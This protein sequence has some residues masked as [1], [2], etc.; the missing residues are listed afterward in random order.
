MSPRNGSS[1]AASWRSQSQICRWTSGNVIRRRSPRGG[2]SPPR[3]SREGSL[4]PILP[5]LP[6]PEA[7][8]QHHRYRVAVEATPPL[9]LVLI[10][11]QQALGLL[12]I[13]LDPVSPMRVLDHRLQRHSCW[14]I[15]PVILA[16]ALGCLL[17]DQPAESASARRGRPPAA[18]GDEPAPQPALA[19]LPPCH[20]APRP[21]G[22]GF[23]QNV[24]AGRRRVS[25]VCRHSK[26]GTIAV[27]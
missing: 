1:L 27:T 24:R 25:P 11:A 22:L 3:S 14:E 18:Y 17:P 5:F 15:A 23:Y 19:T 8:G 7:I 13:L 12:V 2:K 10:P 6:R 9:D 4:L 21:R 16:L 26:I 20:R